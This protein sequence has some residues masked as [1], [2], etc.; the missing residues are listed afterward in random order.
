MA[1][2]RH[3]QI[4]N[5]LEQY[6]IM[7]IEEFC[8][9]LNIS[10]AT[11]RRDL[12]E[13]EQEGLIK[14]IPGGAILHKEGNKNT[15]GNKFADDEDPS[16]PYKRAIAAEAVR[17][18]NP[19]DTIFIDYGSTNSLIAE[20]L[21]SLPNIGGV[22]IVTNSI[23]IAYKCMK[24]AD[25]HVYVCGGARPEMGS[26]AGIVGPLAEQMIS[27]LRAN[28]SFIGTPGIDIKYGITDPYLSAARI[29]AKMIENSASVIL[30]TDHSK[31]G[32]VNKAYICSIDKINHLI[33]DHQVPE[34]QIQIIEN[35]GV[36]V[37]VA[38][39][40]RNGR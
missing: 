2:K 11:A 18:V 14:R 27:Q 21:V 35:M 22:T 16:L 30:V 10:P 23:D 9:S 34:E 38:S 6:S 12:M 5:L 37:T 26:R 39:P 32:K 33:T 20:L 25:I 40:I 28:I 7:K 3:E 29:K 19:G 15:D 17:L 36:K 24:R 31:F 4:I 8:T 1:A 13:M